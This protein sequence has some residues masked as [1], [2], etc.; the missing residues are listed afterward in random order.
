MIHVEQEGGETKASAWV[1]Q[2]QAVKA[3]LK[4]GVVLAIDD[5]SS[6]S[7]WGRGE[8]W[9]AERINRKYSDLAWRG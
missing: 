5:R 7:R 3:E 4:R 6:R 9:I 8:S 1:D 2:V